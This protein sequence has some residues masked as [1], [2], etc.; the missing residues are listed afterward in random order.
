L[1][2]TL[3]HDGKDIQDG[4]WTRVGAAAD[5]TVM[6]KAA[7]V[8]DKMKPMAKVTTKKP[9]VVVLTSTKM[10]TKKNITAPTTSTTTTKANTNASEG[11]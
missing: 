5:H 1:S 4:H 11:W 6:T 7:E 3:H 8:A 2:L 10:T 9:T